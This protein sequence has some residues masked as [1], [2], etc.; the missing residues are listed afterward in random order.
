VT[1]LTLLLQNV[2]WLRRT[3]GNVP[4]PLGWVRMSVAFVVLVFLI[5]VAG[6]FGPQMLWGS[7]CLFSFLFYLYRAGIVTEFASI[8]RIESGSVV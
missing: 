8:W 3:V 4:R 2:Y 7:L 6:R 1:E 5:V